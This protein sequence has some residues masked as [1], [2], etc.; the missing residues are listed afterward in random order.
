MSKIREILR[1]QGL[2]LSQRQIARAAQASLGVVCQLLIEDS[3]ALVGQGQ[4]QES[5]GLGER[6]EGRVNNGVV[7]E[8]GGSY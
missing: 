1:L 6:W 4:R 5:L 8:N 7:L 2:A 3:D